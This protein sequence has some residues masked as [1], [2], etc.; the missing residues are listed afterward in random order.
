LKIV[1]RLGP[2][3]KTR[4]R[5]VIYCDTIAELDTKIL[6]CTR[7]EQMPLD[8]LQEPR[9]CPMCGNR[10]ISLFFDIPTRSATMGRAAE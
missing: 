9:K 5:T 7:G 4:D 2:K 10:K 6:V 3:P 8:S 1:L